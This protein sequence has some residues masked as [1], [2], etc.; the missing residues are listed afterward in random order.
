MIADLKNQQKKNK[1]FETDISKQEHWDRTETRWKSSGLT[2]AVYQSYSITSCNVQNSY[3]ALFVPF[4]VVLNELIYLLKLNH[5][6]ISFVW[7][8]PVYQLVDFSAIVMKEKIWSNLSGVLSL[9]K[10]KQA[11]SV[12]QSWWCCLRQKDLCQR[13]VLA[14]I[15][16]RHCWFVW[17]QQLLW[18][19]SPWVQVWKVSGWCYLPSLYR[20]GLIVTLGQKKDW[21][22]L[23]LVFLH[24]FVAVEI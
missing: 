14:V 6:Y 23:C 12:S 17:P 3:L 16:V 2:I 15:P 13:N 24:V 19:L 18:M 20:K 8:M 22:L 10:K 9:R 1:K 5:L 11:S 7:S 4:C 21:G